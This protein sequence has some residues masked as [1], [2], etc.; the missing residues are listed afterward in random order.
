MTDS[1]DKKSILSLA[2]IMI[3]VGLSIIVFGNYYINQ[4][5]LAAG[6]DFEVKKSQVYSTPILSPRVA[7]EQT[8]IMVESTPAASPSARENINKNT[9]KKVPTPTIATDE[10]T[11]SATNT[12]T[13]S[14]AN[15]NSSNNVSSPEPNPTETNLIPVPLVQ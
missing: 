4:C 7:G 14:E 2:T 13:S 1:N 12:D 10:K 3:G 6:I 15:N 5:I 11:G 9:T 8:D